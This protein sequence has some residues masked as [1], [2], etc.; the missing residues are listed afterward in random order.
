MTDLESA[1]CGIE[2][3][4]SHALLDE[5]PSAYKD[6]DEVIQ[7]AKSLIEVEHTLFFFINIKGD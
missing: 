7:N 6:I 3:R 1:M 2:F 4:H 5:I